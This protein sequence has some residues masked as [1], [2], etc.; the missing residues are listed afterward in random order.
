[1]NCAK[2][3][4]AAPP[5]GENSQS[6]HHQ[7]RCTRR[8]RNTG[9]WQGQPIG[10][11][12]GVQGRNVAGLSSGQIEVAYTLLGD[13]NLDGLVNG[14]D[15]NILAA[16]LNQSITGWD[17]GDFNYDGL[18]NAADFNDLAANFNQGVSGAATAGDVAALDAFA[19]ANGLSL[20]TS[21]VP[22]PASAMMVMAGLGILAR[23]RRSDPFLGAIH[24][25]W[26]PCGK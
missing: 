4:I 23:R 9:S 16:N 24:L 19:A 20:P 1:M 25:R 6:R 21:S 10:R 22:E 14:S 17:Q 18:V 2:K 15:F 7:H 13:A 3:G 11:G 5:A 12:E 26:L 8:F